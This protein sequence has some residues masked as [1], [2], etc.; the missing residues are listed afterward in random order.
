MLNDTSENRSSIGKGI[1]KLLTFLLVAGISGFLFG[2]GCDTGSI[3]NNLADLNRRVLQVKSYR[4][5]GKYDA[6]DILAD[7]ITNE[8]STALS[9][10]SDLSGLQLR[11]YNIVRQN[12]E[13]ALKFESTNN[14]VNPNSVY[15]VDTN[16]NNLR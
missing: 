10:R 14:L 4:Q 9:S 3:Q 6:A 11:Q 1:G 8:L 5:Q 13:T 16:E 12:L 2:K 15:S 7:Y